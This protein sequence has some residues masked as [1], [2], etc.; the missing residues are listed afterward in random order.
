[1]ESVYIESTVISYFTSR[2]SRDLQVAAHQ[3]ITQEWWL[4]RRELFECYISE[5]VIEEI[6]AGDSEAAAARLDAVAGMLVLDA[7]LDAERLT[8]AILTADALPARAARDAA[9]I[10]VCATSGIDYLLTWNCKHL[11]NAQITRKVRSVCGA[12]GFEV[13]IVCT[14]QELMGG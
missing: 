1:M 8:K 10:A 4:D 14:P 2:F 11:A 3:Q 9:H 13:P 5:I 6:A 7:T 12:Q